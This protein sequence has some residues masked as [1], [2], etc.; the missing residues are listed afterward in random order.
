MTK[1]AS[2]II[3]IVAAVL[4]CLVPRNADACSCVVPGTPE[5]LL[6]ESALVFEGRILSV[7]D[8]ADGGMPQASNF[9]T[10]DNQFEV[11]RA[12]KG[13]RAGARVTVKT[14][15]RLSSCAEPWK[16]GD[17]ILVYAREWQG[18]LI[19]GYC[20][21]AKPSEHAAADFEALGP[22][23]GTDPGCSMAE[24]ANARVPQRQV[25]LGLAALLGFGVMRRARRAV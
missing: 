16:A 2:F 15:N 23:L 10:T 4:L 3:A 1:K 13:T 8:T 19:T 24:S 14:A 11:I 7:T 25:L 6:A 5:Q 20:H 9:F 21:G 22:P 18:Q 17:S 12:W